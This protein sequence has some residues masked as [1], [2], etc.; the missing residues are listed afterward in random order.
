MDEGFEASTLGRC[1]IERVAGWR[2][3]EHTGAAQPIDFPVRAG[4]GT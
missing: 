1:M 4:P 2:F 3:L